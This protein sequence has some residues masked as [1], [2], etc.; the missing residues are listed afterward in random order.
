MALSTEYAEQ[1]AVHEENRGE[2]I[3]YFVLP[4]YN[5][6]E[7]LRHTAEVLHHKF[8]LLVASKNI[9]AA[10]ASYLW[11]MAHPTRLGISFRTCMLRI[12]LYSGGV[13]LAHNRGH[14]N[15]LL[16]ELMTALHSGCDAAI[17][18][19]DDLQD[20]V[21]VVDEFIKNNR[22]GDEIVYGA[23]PSVK[24]IHGSNVRLRRPSIRCSSGW[25]RKP[26]PIIRII[27]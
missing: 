13:K 24:K 19:D 1:L 17:S 5:E 2:P 26:F 8:D 7:G 27:V 14:Q 11:M 18:M 22:E 21:N 23:I 6:A 9:A 20:D 25:V 16:A 4:C 3:V 12:L 10:S 15:A